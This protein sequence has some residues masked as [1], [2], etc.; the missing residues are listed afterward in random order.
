MRHIVEKKRN[1][2]SRYKEGDTIS[3]SLVKVADCFLIL[4]KAFNE[5]YLALNHSIY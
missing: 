4:L 1:E 5:K 2:T 3:N